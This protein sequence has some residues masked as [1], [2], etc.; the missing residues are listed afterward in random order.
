MRT[1]G[2]IVVLPGSFVDR[3]YHPFPSK[4]SIKLYILSM[5][6]TADC[7][8]NICFVRYGKKNFKSGEIPSLYILIDEDLL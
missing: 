4:R 6:C 8:K 3:S 1:S 5:V 7:N 2:A